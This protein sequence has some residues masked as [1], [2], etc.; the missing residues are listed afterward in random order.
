M[1]T[2]ATTLLTI[3]ALCATAHA[4]LQTGIATSATATTAA[5]TLNGVNWT[6]TTSA[7]SAFLGINMGSGNWDLGSTLP[8]DG[9][10]LGTGN[11][12]A[13][14]T[15]RFEFSSPVQDICF[16]VENFDSSSAAIIATDATLTIVDATSGLSFVQSTTNSGVLSTSNTSYDGVGDVILQLSGPTSYIQFD[17]LAGEGANGVFYG[18]AQGTASAT[19]VPEPSS[20]LF[21]TLCFGG[22]AYMRKRNWVSAD[23]SSD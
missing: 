20:F 11:V 16:F 7:S 19:A 21:L 14:D 5:G 12:N 22:F 6:A 18:F 10:F 8:V 15:Q 9:L 1:K 17:Y 23:V 13:G 3:I 4:G 2:A